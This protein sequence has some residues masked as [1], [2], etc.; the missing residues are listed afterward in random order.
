MFEILECYCCTLFSVLYIHFYNLYSFLIYLY[1]VFACFVLCLVLLYFNKILNKTDVTIIEITVV[2][3]TQVVQ[4]K[5]TLNIFLYILLFYVNNNLC[6]VFIF[7]RFFLTLLC[8]VRLI[9]FQI[10]IL[11]KISL[12][13]FV[14]FFNLNTKFLKT[15]NIL[16][17][18]I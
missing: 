18:K 16:T 4:Y 1:F 12:L 15:F 10:T 3:K 14:F 6:I 2:T 13:L 17:I 7:E 5:N 9:F 8:T 11:H